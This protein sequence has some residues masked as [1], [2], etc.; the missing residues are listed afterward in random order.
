MLRLIC[1]CL[2]LLFW[3]FALYLS[4]SMLYEYAKYKFDTINLDQ[5]AIETYR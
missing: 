5:I 2:L 4:Y 1:M 3:L